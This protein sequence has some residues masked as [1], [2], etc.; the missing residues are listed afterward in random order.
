VKIS[1]SIV[2]LS[3]ANRGLGR[4]LLDE[5]LE[6]GAGRV[7]AAA[8]DPRQLGGLPNA[9]VP[10]ALDLTSPAK[11]TAAAK[12]AADVTLLL[13]NASAAVF[14]DPVSADRDAMWREVQT[15]YLGTV[16]LTRALLP[17]LQRAPEGAVVNVLSLL[18]LASA[19]PMA[20]YSASKAALHSYTQAL[21]GALAGTSVSVHGVYPGGIDTDML[22]GVDAP[23]TAPAVVARLLCDGLEAGQE[24]IF[25]DPTSEQM[26]QMWFSDPKAFE[27]AFAG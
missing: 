14:A 12:Q 6:R 16:D 27:R 15:N 19:P 1:D 26:S 3:G 11:I 17:A 20:G 4:A 2:F 24:D 18:A 7:Y 22:A 25:P 21:R 9:V 23:K 10:I 8:R 5:L 13:N